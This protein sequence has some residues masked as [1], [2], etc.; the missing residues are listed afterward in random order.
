MAQSFE[1]ILWIRGKNEPE[2]RKPILI[3]LA[4]DMMYWH[5]GTTRCKWRPDEYDVVREFPFENGK[6]IDQAVDA[7]DKE[8]APKPQEPCARLGFVSPSGEFFPCGYGC[9]YDLET[10]LG[11][12]FYQ[13]GCPRLRS[14][15]WVEIQSNG[16]ICMDDKLHVTPAA[17]ATIQKIVEAFEYEEAINPDVDWDDVLERNPE[18]YSSSSIWSSATNLIGDSTYAKEIR[19]SYE[20]YF[21]DNTQYT[22][23]VTPGYGVVNPLDT[24]SVRRVDAHPGD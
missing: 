11:G 12:L 18:G 16:I 14:K 24:I 22:K 10:L 5:A 8:Y 7:L 4:G 13:T 9:H 21:G 1:K 23:L 15:G 6:S 17:K 19:E 20:L 2:T 3:G